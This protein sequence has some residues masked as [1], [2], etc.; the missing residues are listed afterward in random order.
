MAKSKRK[1]ASDKSLPI[2]IFIALWALLGL[3]IVLCIIVFSLISN[4]KIGYMPPIEELQNPKNKFATEVYT[5]DGKLLTTYFM[6]TD[7]RVSVEYSQLSPHLVRALIATED[8]RFTQ[9]SGIDFKALLR[10][11]VKRGLLRQKSAGGGSTLTQQL[12]KQ[13]YTPTAG[14]SFERILQKPIEWVIAVKLER[15]Y[16]KEEILTMYLNKFDFLYNAVGIKNASKVYFNTTPDALNI[17]QAA[18]LVGMFKNPSLYNPIRRKENSLSRRNLVIQQMAEAKFISQTECDSLKALPLETDYQRMSHTEGLAPYFRQYLRVTMMHSK[19]ERKNYASWQEQ[20]YRDDSLA[21]ETDPLF[22]WCKKNRKRDGGNYNIYTDGLKIYTTIDSRMQQYAEEAVHEHIALD[23]QPK[24]FR[25]K[26]GRSYAPYTENLSAQQV[27]SILW[28]NARQSERYRVLRKQGKTAD[29][30]A[31]IFRTPIPMEIFTYNGMVDATMSPLDSIR[32]HK[33][34]LRAGFM[35]MDPF[36]GHV[37]AYVGGVSFVPFQ[38]D[39]VMQGRRQVGSTIKPYL[40]TLAMEEGFQPCDPVRNEPITLMTENGE[41]WSPRNSGS[42]QVG[43]M[44]TLRWG[45]ANSNNWISAYLMGKL[46]PYSFVNMLRSFGIRGHLDPVYSLC[47]GS[48]DVSVGEMTSAYT[49]FVNN[50]IRVAPLFVTRIEDN[51]GNTLE[52]FSPRMSEVFSQETAYKMQTMLRAV[53][54]E[55]T[56]VRLRFRYHITADM[57]G[58]TGTTQNNSDGWFMGITPHLVSGAWGGGEDRDIHFDHMSDGQGANI[59]LPIYA[60]YMNKVY[61]DT[62][63]GYLQTDSFA[64]PER[65]LQPCPSTQ[66]TWE[67]SENVEAMFDNL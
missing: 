10:A 1:A 28:Q 12:A 42:K 36:N 25:E 33:H 59:A 45:L 58:K 3:G 15:F 7:N 52:Q 9:H 37:K 41:A 6:D 16:T 49:A 40:Y 18:T 43:E 34:F 14:N 39:M 35:S 32:Y 50:G 55:G 30:I 65:Y 4:G 20:L 63:L 24:F 27:D 51:T 60:L 48:C 13:M 44:V 47:L 11:I 26:K 53:I 22:G 19:P 21:W 46:S 29:E 8:V 5:S 57:G 17:E 31:K 62:T 38:Y 64:I 67:E 54:N 23:L 66:T 2:K 61:A 56:G